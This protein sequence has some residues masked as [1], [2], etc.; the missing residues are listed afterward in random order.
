MPIHIC[1]CSHAGSVIC[2]KGRL[3]YYLCVEYFSQLSFDSEMYTKS[4]AVSK[5]STYENGLDSKFINFNAQAWSHEVLSPY[6]PHGK[7]VS[8]KY[9][10]LLT[11]KMNSK[12]DS[13]LNGRNIPF[14]SKFQVYLLL[15]PRYFLRLILRTAIM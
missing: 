6:Q 7:F 15:H 2:T 1:I 13:L 12:T 10:A 8:R 5:Q 9:L 4:A 14:S 11:V 3:S